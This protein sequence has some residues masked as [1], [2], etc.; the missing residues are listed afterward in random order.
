MSELGG[1]GPEGLPRALVLTF[2]NLGEASELERG[3]WPARAPLGRHPSVTRALPRLLDQLDAHGLT[4]TFFVEAINCELNPSAVREIAGRGHELGVHGW[5]HEPWADLPAGRERELLT[6]GREAFHELGLDARA[7]RP[8][9][10]GLT[11]S[12]QA[13]LPEL[14]FGWCSPL[15]GAPMV[16]EPEL[17]V[18]PFDWELVDAYHLMGRFG[19]LRARR[20]DHPAPMPADHLAERFATALAGGSGVQ[21]LI[22]HPFLML[23]EAWFTGVQRLLALIEELSLAGRIWVVPGGRFADWLRGLDAE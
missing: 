9:G 4:A 22:L 3:T 6:R 19:E 1:F 16:L 13:L 7:F 18:V 2:D 15:G 10:G 12:S 21:T 8:P 5:R 11:A 23:D 20:G 17:A 14:G